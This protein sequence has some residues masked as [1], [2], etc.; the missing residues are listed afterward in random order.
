MPL[1]IV[2]NDI[3]KMKVDAI[4]NPVTDEPN[5]ISLEIIKA[6]GEDKLQHELDSIESTKTG[7]PILTSGYNLPSKY[8]IHTLLP[9]SDNSNL[10]NL[11]NFYINSIKLA[12][13]KNLSSIALPLFSESYEEKSILELFSENIRSSISNTEIEVYLVLFQKIPDTYLSNLILPHK[14]YIV[15]NYSGYEFDNKKL[16]GRIIPCKEVVVED[17]EQHLGDFI[18]DTY[19]VPP[20]KKEVIYPDK[21]K[22]SEKKKKEYIYHD[23]YVPSTSADQICCFKT[24]IHS[25]RRIPPNLSW[26]ISSMDKPF[27]ETLSYIIKEKG[28]SDSDVYNKANIDRKAFSKIRTGET[29]IPKKPTI[30]ALAIA[31]ELNLEETNS[32][33]NKAGYILSNSLIFDVIVKSFIDKK[34]YDIMEINIA[35][36][37]YDQALLGSF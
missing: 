13:N 23:R 18:E 37:D 36:Y 4:V 8:I 20:S 10:V 6:V 1:F 2:K 31:L 33:L 35:L 9:F 17:E 24:I 34:N 26:A 27:N 30:L 28:K 5:Q 29:K 11:L 19:Y 3:T 12:I 7:E 21:L 14:Q 22:P 16:V 32:L 25:E 15:E